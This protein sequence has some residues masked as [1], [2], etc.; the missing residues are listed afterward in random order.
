M[1]DIKHIIQFSFDVQTAFKAIIDEAEMAGYTGADTTI[2]REVGGEISCWDGYISAMNLEIVKNK[3][4][5][6]SWRASEWAEGHMSE[7]I[8]EFTEKDG[9]TELSFTHLNVPDEFGDAI[10]KGWYDNYWN[11]MIK[12]Y[13]S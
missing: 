11:L 1:V 3:R 12:Y 2:S 8:F 10:D 13:S 4:I 6:Q 7:V 9:G 5:R